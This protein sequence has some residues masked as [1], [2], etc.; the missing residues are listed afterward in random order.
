MNRLW[1]EHSAIQRA[2]DAVRAAIETDNP[3]EPALAMLIAL[4]DQHGRYEESALFNELHDEGGVEEKLAEL[5]REHRSLRRALGN[6]AAGRLEIPAVIAALDLLQQHIRRE[7]YGL[8]PAAVLLL[9]NDAWERL[10][11]ELGTAV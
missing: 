9:G 6:A 1:A 11:A 8:F 4:I 5:H 7:E 10:D 2:A 3:I